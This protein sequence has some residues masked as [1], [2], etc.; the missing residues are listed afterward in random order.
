MYCNI[1]SMDSGP[2]KSVTIFIIKAI[3]EPKSD[4]IQHQFVFYFDWIISV[5]N[6]PS[7]LANSY[8]EFM[9]ISNWLCSNVS[10][11]YKWM[12]HSPPP[13]CY[14]N[15]VASLLRVSFLPCSLGEKGFEGLE[16]RKGYECWG[17]VGGEEIGVGRGI[18]GALLWVLIVFNPFGTV[19]TP[20]NAPELKICMCRVKMLNYTLWLPP[21]QI[22]CTWFPKGT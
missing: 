9:S 2:V 8:V 11:K 17:I 14:T 3:S 7:Q 22:G 15:G 19:K 13:R 1:P 21:C 16:V 4:S 6:I 18:E 20:G 12:Y 5:I 10:K